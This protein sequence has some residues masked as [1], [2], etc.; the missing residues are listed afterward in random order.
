MEIV[1]AG[2]GAV[3]FA[4]PGR[5]FEA[6]ERLAEELRRDGA[7][8]MLVEGGYGR[9]PGEPRPEADRVALAPLVNVVPVQLF[10]E[11]L[12]R[13]RGLPGQ[14]RRITKVVKQV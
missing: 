2:L 14:F 12:A 3:L 7:A 6:T 9:T 4:A 5:A 10:V 13:A 11:A 8:V 1:E